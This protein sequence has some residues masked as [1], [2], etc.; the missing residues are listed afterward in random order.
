MSMAGMRNR[1]LD[2]RVVR[3]TKVAYNVREL[4]NLDFRVVQATKVAYN[5]RELVQKLSKHH[6]IRGGFVTLK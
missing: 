3:A 2:F 5:V 4:V 1:L 6:Q